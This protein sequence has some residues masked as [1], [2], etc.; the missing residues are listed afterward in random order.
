MKNHPN[1]KS[2]YL[3]ISALFFCISANSQCSISSSTGYTVNI[4]LKPIQVNA[5]QKCQYGY[6]YTVDM[7]YDITFSGTNIP[8]NMY[9]LQGNLTCGS[10][11]LFFGLPNS[12][13]TG[14]TTTSN[15]YTSMTNC[16][17]VTPS[18]LNCNT[19]EIQISGPGLDYTTFTCSF[20]TPLP[21]EL[22]DFS[23]TFTRKNTVDLH[24]ITASEFNNSHF[25]LQRSQNG[26]D[27]KNIAQVAGNG[28]SESKI[29][30]SFT[31]ETA[32]Q[33]QTLY[34][35]L[36][37]Y[38]FNGQTELSK[39]ISIQPVTQ[40]VDEID[41]YPNPVKS[42]LTLEAASE[43]LQEFALFS[44]DG[45]LIENYT[46]NSISKTHMVLNIQNLEPGTYF[47]GTSSVR[48]RFV[49]E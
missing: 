49:K 4:A 48:K 32:F 25:N 34:Y 35:R 15:N 45:R 23:G 37:Q 11:N 3:S 27:W 13:G 7:V 6:N 39:I 29:N 24:W 31:D 46:K 8:N 26:L 18:A 2:V 33:K 22:I 20:N 17:T 40:N 1:F 36:E 44:I 47:V 21:V 9:T 43:W 30:Y 14:L 42:T 10:T 38:D 5:P 12:G 41:V 28:N 16:S 19:A